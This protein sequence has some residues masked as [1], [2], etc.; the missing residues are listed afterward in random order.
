MAT[1]HDA[2]VE[3]EADAFRPDRR[4]FLFGVAANV[5]LAF[6][7]I[8]LPYSRA[9][10]RAHDARHE[11]AKFAACF[12]GGQALED[13]G[14]ALPAGEREAYAH[15][16][17]HGPADWP[18]RCDKALTAISPS[19]ATFLFPSVKQADAD[20]RAAID[21]FR[22]ES[23]VLRQGRGALGHVPGRPLLAFSRLRG[24]LAM[25]LDAAGDPESIDRDAISLNEKPQVIVPSRVPLSA[26][27]GAVL[28]MQS[29]DDVLEAHALD[30]RGLSWV[31]VA[32]G[33]VDRHRPKRSRL[34]RALTFAPGPLLV[35]ALSEER[36]KSVTN[37][38]VHRAMGASTFEKVGPDLP[39][40]QWLTAHPPGRP[41]RHVQIHDGQLWVTALDEG[42]AQRELRAFA[43]ETA[44]TDDAEPI[45]ATRLWSLGSEVIHDSLLLRTAPPSLI[46]ATA[47]G[48]ASVVALHTFLPAQAQ[49]QLA[50]LPGTAP[51]LLACRTADVTWIA[52]FTDAQALLIRREG[53][54]VVT[55]AAI[56]KGAPWPFHPDD[57]ARDRIRLLCN[58]DH[59]V[60]LTLDAARS[61]SAQACD[62]EM[63]CTPAR[64][65]GR[66][67]STYDALL[68]A[69]DLIVATAGDTDHAQTQVRTFDALLVPT[70]P[71][72]TPA[73]CWQPAEG[74]CGQPTLIQDARRVLLA[75]REQSDLLVIESLD[76][77]A[78]WQPMTGLK[79]SQDLAP[80]GTIMNIHR[81]RKRYSH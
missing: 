12:L 19:Q 57:P 42:P 81:D 8:V 39:H 60:V 79:V 58:D 26:A 51:F 67:T 20:T 6:L 76:S 38:C 44:K 52:A 53:T 24:A 48:A 15:Q 73:P 18:A 80:D 69:D 37:G 59:A 46:T 3:R 27:T 21:L 49:Q 63:Q 66:D 10:I 40:P 65:V 71:A 9:R 14:L 54:G 17:M 47:Q 35:W 78:T 36:C 64:E 62:N 16:V 11:L 22:K 33:K 7:F 13:P 41:D 77:G 4:P 74:M 23:A 68:R 72:Q 31:R 25:L 32:Q 34:L 45:G 2:Q 61:L 50:T 43:L 56:G 55:T 28:H 1:Q 29:N 75:A 5:L 70:G 30:L